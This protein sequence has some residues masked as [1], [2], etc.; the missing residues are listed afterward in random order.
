MQLGTKKAI[1]A[2][3]EGLEKALAQRKREMLHAAEEGGEVHVGA[4]ELKFAASQ[5]EWAL[6]RVADFKEK[7][8]KDEAKKGDEEE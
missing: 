5:F 2:R 8:G 4:K 6:K 3:L 1:N 7:I